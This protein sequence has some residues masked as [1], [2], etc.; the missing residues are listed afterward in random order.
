MFLMKNPFFCIVRPELRRLA[1]SEQ[2]SPLYKTPSFAAGNG[3]KG[4]GSL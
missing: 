4:N 1:A 3:G 2:L